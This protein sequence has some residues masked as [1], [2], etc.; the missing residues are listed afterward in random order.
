MN[1][2]FNEL[3]PYLNQS[4]HSLL[5]NDNPLARFPNVLYRLSLSF[6]DAIN[7]QYMEVWS[8]QEISSTLQS[9][10]DIIGFFFSEYSVLCFTIAVLLNRL[11]TTISRRNRVNR[12]NL[13]PE[14]NTLSHV[15]CILLLTWVMY[16]LIEG[17]IKVK[18]YNAD[19]P[20]IPLSLYFMV[21]SWSYCVETVISLLSNSTPL[22]GSDYTIFEISIEFYLLQRKRINIIDQTEFLPDCLMAISNRVMIHV[23]EMYKMRNYRLL[24][25]ASLNLVHITYLMYVSIKYGVSSIPILTRFRHFPKVFSLFIVLISLVSYLLAYIIRFDPFTNKNRNPDELQ[26]Y[27]FMK[28]WRKHLNF[29]GEEDFSPMLSKLA[30]LLTSASSISERGTRYEYPSVNINHELDTRY[31]ERLR[32]IQQVRFNETPRNGRRESVVIALTKPILEAKQNIPFLSNMLDS[33]KLVLVHLC[34]ILRGNEEA[35]YID[36][37]DSDADKEVSETPTRRFSLSKDT[38]WYD[39][40]YSEDEDYQDSDNAT[41]LSLEE[42]L[43]DDDILELR[44]DMSTLL[45]DELD[46]LMLQDHLLHS[47]LTRSGLHKRYQ[48]PSLSQ[49]SDNREDTRDYSCVVCKTN[50]RNVIMWPCSCFAVCDD[51][52]VS[53]S[54][55]GFNTC[56]CC[57][58]PVSGHS[59]THAT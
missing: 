41:E 10:N 39:D 46:P 15:S 27:S 44:D 24:G 29:T 18:I 55:R 51:C 5:A 34:E 21:F 53:L 45:Q 12:A 7:S 25:S 11:I 17:L 32:A 43:A 2:T 4:S 37:D 9:F 22:E 59:K 1:E 13:R 52:R 40:S 57:R 23:L 20:K 6:H 56:V 54:V 16:E 48:E 28:N 33:F 3:F 42:D 47:R 14:I 58:A 26:F 19:V 50:D 30:I 35:E 8:G 49:V 36:T 38:S 31:N